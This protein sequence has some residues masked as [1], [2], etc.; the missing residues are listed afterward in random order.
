MTQLGQKT[1]FMKSDQKKVSM[2]LGKHRICHISQLPPHR[3]RLLVGS[4]I[5]TCRLTDVLC[6]PH[7]QGAAPKHAPKRICWERNPGSRHRRLVSQ[8]AQCCS[9]RHWGGGLGAGGGGDRGQDRLV[10]AGAVGDFVLFG[11]SMGL[12]QAAVELQVSFALLL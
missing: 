12:G 11:R 7:L 1:H 8:P 5:G 6:R 10:Q 4:P 3:V 2:K 9:S